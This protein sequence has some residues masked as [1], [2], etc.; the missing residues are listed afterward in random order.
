MRLA[1]FRHQGR[2]S[3]GLV[4]DAGIV[5]LAPAAGGRFAGLKDALAAGALGDLTA[6]A[7]GR[8]ALPFAAIEWLPPI[9][10][11]GKILCVGL[12]YRRHAEEAGMKV[13]TRPSI[14][15]RF[16]DSQVGHL[17]PVIRPFASEQ[18][19]YE[20]ELAVVIGRRARHVSAEQALGVVAGY[21]CFAEN[22]VRDF[23]RHAA[24]ATPGKN[25]TASGAFG[26]WLVTADE[27]PD[28]GR[29]MLT[30]RLNGEVVQREST[31]DMI[32]SVPQ[33]IEYLS[34]WTELQPG[35]V[36][37][38]GTPSG[39]GLARK[40]PLWLKPGD[41]FEVEIEKIGTLANTV[42]DETRPS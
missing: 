8:A 22:S 34:T 10:D 39:V 27:I 37:S 23:Q 20:G 19:D 36:I 11:S 4:T 9:P 13:P 18:F 3:F 17:Q 6:A 2:R 30:S 25:F 42:V 7:S 41:R 32:F 28:P 26:P 16:A 31:G 5:D 14:F 1:S 21:A 33:L 15:V 40:P 29:L 35:D 38:T 12:N 24:Q